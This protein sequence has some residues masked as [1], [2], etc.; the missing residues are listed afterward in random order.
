M[1]IIN[2]IRFIIGV[3]FILTGLCFFVT[4]IIGIFKFK[5]VLNRMHVA[6]VGDTLGLSVTLLGTIFLSGFNFTTLKMILVVVFLWLAAPVASHLIARL[7][8]T[9]NDDIEEYCKVSEE[10]VEE[11]IEEQIVE[12]E[13]A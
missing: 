7:E 9:T 1:E 10:I 13:E 12:K 2:I 11:V 3:I 5:Y 8:V 4:E 6:G